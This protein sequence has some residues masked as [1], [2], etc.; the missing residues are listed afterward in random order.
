MESRLQEK[1]NNEEDL[2]EIEKEIFEEEFTK[3]TSSNK[4][5]LE[6]INKELNNM[7]NNIKI[8][9]DKIEQIKRNLI[10]LKNKKDKQQTDLINLLAK[11][12]S[13]EEIYKNKIFSLNTKNENI[14]TN[15]NQLEISNITVDDFKQIEINKY[16]E[17]V[18]LMTEDILAKCG[19]KYNKNDIINDLKK[20]IKNSY[21]IFIN[22]SSLKNLDF[23]FNN[24]ITKISL[25]ISNQSFGKFSEKNINICLKYLLE[26][27]I[28]N[29]TIAK[30]N[31][32]LNKQYKEK[33]AELKIEIKNLENKNEI[34]YQID[35]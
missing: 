22:N 24:F 17:Q 8:N 27:N 2:D 12:E 34:Y 29:E 25:Y 15:N 1:L 13:I 30:M 11:K 4:N 28:I 33:K 7:Q 18:I 23:I 26:I 5:K 21:E 3:E 19:Q 10:L 35:T 31:K 14:N 32:F 6:Q 16:I 20:I 9:N